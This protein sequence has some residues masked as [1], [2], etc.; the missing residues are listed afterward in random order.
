MNDL[1]EKALL[2]GQNK[3]IATEEFLVASSEK[4]AASFRVAPDLISISN[5]SANTVVKLDMKIVNEG[6]FEIE[7][8]AADPFISL[9]KRIIT[10]DDFIGGVYYFP[11]TIEE[12][13]LHAG[14]NYSKITLRSSTQEVIIPVIVNIK[15]RS[16]LS[17]FNT[18]KIYSGLMR[19][20]LEY[21]KGLIGPKEWMDSSNALIDDASGT[22]IES[23]YLMLYQAHMYTLLE[24]Y[25]N[26]AN[27]MEFMADQLA[28]LS[29]MDYELFCYFYYVECLYERDEDQINEAVKRVKYAYKEHP[30]WKILWVLIN[31]DK[32]YDGQIGLKLDA[33]YDCF[34]EGCHSPVMYLEALEI[35]KRNSHFLCDAS[36]FEL[37]VLCFGAKSDYLNASISTRFSELILGFNEREIRGINKT[38]A[39]KVLKVMYDRFPNRSILKA[40]CV[41]LIYT[42]NKEKESSKYY[43]EAIR[44]YLD[45]IP[46]VYKFFFDSVDKTKYEEIPTKI[47]EFFF[48]NIQDLGN[49]TSYVFANLV[50]NK[51]KIPDYYKSCLGAMVHYAER[52][53]ARGVVDD[54]LIIIYRDILENNLLTSNIQRGLFEVLATNRIICKSP[55]MTS[56]MVI[57]EE[58]S[59]YQDVV[60]VNGEAL[61]KIYSGSAIILFKDARGNIYHNIDYEK[62]EL[63]NLKEYVDLCIKGVPLNDYMLLQDTLPMTRNF[64]DPV[65]ILHYLNHD[66]NASEFRLSYLQKIINDTVV[67]FSRTSK[68]Q[69]VYD[70]L[71]RFFKFDLA[72]ETRAKLIEI[73]IERTLYKDAYEEIKKGG[74]ENIEPES[75]AKLAHV[76]T[77][78]DD[79]GHDDLLLSMCEQSFVRTPFD[80]EIFNYLLKNYNDKLSVMLD[81]Y[82]ASNAYGIEDDSLP[83][84]ILRR[85]IETHEYPELVVQLFAKYYEDGPDEQLKKDFLNF[86]ASRYFYDNEEKNADFFKYVEMGLINRVNFDLVTEISYLK[87]MSD[88]DISSSRRIKMIEEK[89]KNLTSRSIM[90]EEFKRYKKY[91]ELPSLLANSVII[92]NMGQKAIVTYTIDDGT[93]SETKSEMMREIIDGFYAKYITL[94]YGEKV[95]YQVE[96]GEEV[97]VSYEDLDIVHDESRYSSIDNLIKL[98]NQDNY[99][100]LNLLARE[101][102][103]KSEL[104]DRL[105]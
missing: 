97:T 83:E 98:E 75:I 77:E 12:S 29:Y 36:D 66:V 81:L 101:Y 34:L 53:I 60:L 95:T 39:I 23:M 5:I 30:T 62:V 82:R 99:E 52:Q 6:Y 79:A 4:E 105:F 38:L 59:T 70:E 31:L 17:D 63:I 20:Y 22:D 103:V 72:P 18:R 8:S 1:L 14:K 100:E 28:K 92:T 57:H 32:N 26:A 19:L 76:L 61:V 35:F 16:T 90:L 25:T 73:M 51:N 89:I 80:K 2:I 84:R 33:I 96:D 58:L 64:K 44:E 21:K 9:E 94:F 48:D 13:K 50:E 24:M 43:L 87:Y 93:S 42:N 49:Y 69:E 54:H 74:F 45:N 37:Q 27:I 91:F 10:S 3:K 41:L 86:M 68:E 71:I 56:V 78:L 11:V 65:E 15:V 85:T 102:F 7:A 46:G 104:I 40:L 88:K 67:Y 47:L 55:R